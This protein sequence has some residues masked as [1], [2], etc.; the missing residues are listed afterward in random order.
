MNDTASGV[1]IWQHGESEVLQRSEHSSFK[2]FGLD[3]DNIH[4]YL[5][6]SLDI[7]VC[8]PQIAGLVFQLYSISSVSQNP[9][10][11]IIYYKRDVSSIEY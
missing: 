7:S 2:K 5:F 3:T 8:H 6:L 4:Q 1:V 9:S 10:L 11:R